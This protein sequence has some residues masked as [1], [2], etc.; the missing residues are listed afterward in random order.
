MEQGLAT[1]GLWGTA[2]YAVL[3]D[4]RLAPSHLGPET[5][6]PQR[7]L[8]LQEVLAAALVQ[9]WGELVCTPQ[10]HLLQSDSQQA[11][12]VLKHG[13]FALN[14]GAEP[15]QWVQGVGTRQGSRWCLCR[16]HLLEA[17]VLLTVGAVPAVAV[18]VGHQRVLV[19][20]PAVDHNVCRFHPAGRRTR[21]K[22]VDWPLGASRAAVGQAASP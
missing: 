19:A 22:L 7:Q 20:E 1:H 4:T 21:G 13:S 17:V 10:W 6:H 12:V 15:G 14:E 9:S 18:P 3:Q 11:A 16:P 5:I 8:A 2:C